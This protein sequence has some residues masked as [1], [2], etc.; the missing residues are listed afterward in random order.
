MAISPS[1]SVVVPNSRLTFQA[2]GGTP[3]YV[4]S[5]FTNRSG[6]SIDPTTGLYVAGPHGLVTDVV[7][8]TD[9]LATVSDAMVRLTAGLWQKT[10]RGVQP[11]SEQLPVAQVVEGNYG[12]EKDIMFERARQGVLSNM[13]GSGPADSLDIVG[14]E[15]QLPRAVDIN[16]VAVETDV[17]FGERLR[18]SWDADDGWTSGGA[19]GPLLRALDR[20][21]F[22]MGD[23]AGAHIIQV[24]KRWSWLSA[25]GGVPVYSTHA[26]PWTFGGLPLWQPNAFAIVFGAD[27]PELTVG[28]PAADRLQ[29]IVERWAPVKARFMGT[30][31]IVSGLAWGWP[32]GVHTWGE[33]G[34]VWGGTVRKIPPL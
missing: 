12:A 21:G 31:I 23:P 34:L 18:T 30:W 13:P 5:I 14:Q 26:R 32:P 24:Y 20:G 22:P 28:S 11:P 6:G 2:S 10:Q 8:A 7:R 15:R 25:S 3:P 1:I 16:G 29:D 19:H 9:S 33:L 17:A 27:V 4:F